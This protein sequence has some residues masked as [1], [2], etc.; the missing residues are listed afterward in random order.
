[1]NRTG[2][3]LLLYITSLALVTSC[4]R[5]GAPTGGD[6]DET[7]P[8]LV[9]S[10][11]EDGATGYMGNIIQLTFD[12]RIITRS[13]ETDLILTPKPSGTFRVRVNKN[14]LSLS[15]TEPF[16]ENTTYSLSFGNTIQDITNNN[17]A[18]GINLSFSTGDYIDSLSIQG[19]ILN[20]YDQEPIENLLVSLYSQNDSVDILTG[21]ASY[22]SRTDS[23]GTYRFR[24][25]PS[26]TFRV[27]AVRDKNNNSQADSDKEA[28]GFY[29]DTLSL[30]SSVRDID[31]TIQNLNTDKLRTTSARGFGS[32]FDITFNKS[33]SDFNIIQGDEFTYDQ[34]ESS[35][36]RFYPMG[37]PYRDTTDLIFSARD[38]LNVLH[39]D[40][41][42]VFFNESKLNSPAF[43]FEISPSGDFMPPNDT[44]KILFNK[45]VTNVNADSLYIQ[46]DSILTIPID[47]QL[48]VW[49][50]LNTELS[51][52]L[53]IVSLLNQTSSSNISISLR[54]AAFISADNDSSTLLTKNMSLLTSDDSAI[55]GGT[56]QSDS[57]NIIVQLLDA[58]TLKV[59]RTSSSKQFLF[60]YLAAGRYMVRVVKD[61]N[62][63]GKW[64][65]G[66]I[67]N[68]ENPEPVKF[69]FD[70]FYKTKVIEVRKNWEQ[71]DANVFF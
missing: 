35:A 3:Y 61:L 8:V 2:R 7:P 9:K 47:K 37:R 12:E 15:F 71:T 28:Y 22:Y 24:N 32:Y 42:S 11:P 43:S 46:L 17:P 29:K 56:V 39:Q 18:D 34:P 21:A 65:I 57:N 48:L 19:K 6:E 58:R 40:T 45:P 64:D 50:E 33:I 60:K 51:Y 14:I 54:S 66:N 1:M 49:N 62:S 10:S 44:L 25:L 36:I 59:V 38:S 67:L 53:D 63:N 26:G 27:Y 55:I 20:L 23:A 31:F 16:D 5:V 30:N 69:Y 70:E 41:V 4:A 13:I 68:W 52:P